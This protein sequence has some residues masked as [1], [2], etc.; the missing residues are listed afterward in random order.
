MDGSGSS[1]VL[2]QGAYDPVHP[3]LGGWPSPERQLASS[4]IRANANMQGAARTWSVMAPFPDHRAEDIRVA[5]VLNA[6]LEFGDIQ[7]RKPLLLAYFW[8]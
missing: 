1:A 6:E 5:P 4:Q 7:R 2:S 3:A 8:V